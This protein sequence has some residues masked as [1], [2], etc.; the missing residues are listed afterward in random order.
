MRKTRQD[1]EYS[2]QSLWPDKRERKPPPPY[3]S[4]PTRATTRGPLRFSH[5]PP[6]NDAKPS[7]KMLI[8]NVNVTSEML[9]PNCFASGTRNTLHAYTAPKAICRKTPATAIAQRF[10]F[11]VPKFL[12]FFLQFFLRGRA[13]LQ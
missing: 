11:M 13:R 1:L 7:T 12:Y 10:V 5:T 2:Q 3:R 8:V 4:P 6:K 9:Q